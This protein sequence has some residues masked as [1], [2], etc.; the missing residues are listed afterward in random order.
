MYRFQ[1]NES[2]RKSTAAA[3]DHLA[4]FQQLEKTD[5]TWTIACPTYLPDGEETGKYRTG[6]NVLP[7]NGIKISVRD[8]AA[9][10]YKEFTEQT[11]VHNRVGLAY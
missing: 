6:K 10:A 5:L 7:E 3:E 2:K 11:C 4:A 1:T 8:T 9:F